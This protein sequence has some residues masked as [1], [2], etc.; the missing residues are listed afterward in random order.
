MIDPW[1]DPRVRAGMEGQLAH[2]ARLIREGARPLGW[3]VA[4]G[5]P[6]VREPLGLAGPVVGFLTDVTLLR[7]GGECEVGE[8]L[9]PK[10]EPEIAVH[11]GAGGAIVGITAAIELADAD[12]PPTEL[13]QVVGGDI[14]HRRVVL[15]GEEPVPLPDSPIAV[16]VTRDGEPLAATEDAE[17]ATGNL[18]ELIAHVATYLENFGCELAAGE[19]V[20][21]GSTV[22]L[23]DVA[24]GER[25]R[26]EVAGVGAVEVLLT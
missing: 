17:A 3:K 16:A 21:S 4:F 2:R 26:S 1:L 18:P 25:V 15:G 10:L 5:P 19:V 23:I 11:V 14:Y 24:P 22:P 8:W 12:L 6:A 9:A 20:I 7:S 13:E